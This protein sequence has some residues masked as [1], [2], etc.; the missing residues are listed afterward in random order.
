MTANRAL[1]VLLCASLLSGGC[2]TTRALTVPTGPAAMPAGLDAVKS[3]DRLHIVWRDGRDEWVT[4]ERPTEG[5]F[6]TTMDN[7]PYHY[8]D[9]ASIDRQTLH[10]GRT[11]LAAILGIAVAVGL[12]WAFSADFFIG[13]GLVLISS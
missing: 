4:V 6:F 11:T 7:R 5:G 10:K 2:H 1:A 3:G 8:A 13:S 9:I 12:I